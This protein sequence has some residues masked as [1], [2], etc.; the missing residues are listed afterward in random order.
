MYKLKIMNYKNYEYELLQ[1]EL[2]DLSQSGYETKQIHWLT[3]FKKTNQNYHY[4]VDL[5]HPEGK[6]RF[7]K[8]ISQQ[9]F[10]D[11]YLDHDYQI[12]LHKKGLYVFK[13]THEIKR[14]KKIN[15]IT[16]IE[17]A[18]S[19]FIFIAITILSIF[20]YFHSQQTIT[21]DFLS[22]YG[23]TFLYAGILLLLL[24]CIYYFSIKTYYLSQLRSYFETN[25]K[26]VKTS[27]LKIHHIIYTCLFIISFILILA[28]TIE[29]FFNPKTITLQEH[30]T[31][32]IHDLYIDQS[33]TISYTKHSGFQ[34]PQYYQYLEYTDDEKYI[35]QI[36][37]YIFNSSQDAQNIWEELALKPEQYQC[38]TITKEN[39]VI[40]G[41]T[42]KQ[43]T[44]I[45]ILNNE[46][47]YRISFNFDLTQQQIDT[48]LKTYQ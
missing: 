17:I 12:I 40:Y 38:D 32:T 33:S 6:S 8:D 36:K 4:I 42:D 1:N 5:F 19:S 21:I 44:C 25:K 14:P 10:L 31:M 27:V 35:L 45:I 47:V 20:F 30:P 9:K 29:D 13:G 26:N 18:K 43:L 48:I 37:E 28:G 15:P 23:L 39:H 3:L 2:N 11:P 7:D 24:T 34:I 16:H 22:S 41:Y 46:H